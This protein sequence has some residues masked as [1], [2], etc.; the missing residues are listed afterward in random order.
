MSFSQKK[1]QPSLIGILVSLEFIL[2]Y[3]RFRGPFGNFSSF[4]R[5]PKIVYV[6]FDTF[7]L[8]LSCFWNDE[9]LNFFLVIWKLIV[10]WWIQVFLSR[11]FLDYFRHEI[12]LNT[13]KN[14]I[15]L[16]Q[17]HSY[18]DDI[19]RPTQNSATWI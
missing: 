13:Q 10:Q 3:P 1:I 19:E 5:K 17:I 8:K 12:Y 2:M 16:T 15:L 11:M 7:L 14:L 6:I 4:E 9:I 18:S